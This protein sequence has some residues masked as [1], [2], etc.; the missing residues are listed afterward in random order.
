MSRKPEFEAVWVPVGYV[1]QPGVIHLEG[2]W[3]NPWHQI[4]YA[5]WR[6]RKRLQISKREAADRAGISE[7][8][9]RQLEGGG[10]L[11][12]GRVIEPN[13]RPENLYKALKA[14]GDV[15]EWAFAVLYWDIPEPLPT[16]G[17]DDR[18]EAKL[19]RL[20]ERD[21]AVIETAVDAMLQLPG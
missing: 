17:F 6:G 16:E 14:V 4:G 1:H 21:R 9:W 3:S 11:V 20:S 7:A 15:P 18:L 8:L 2:D 19:A 5:L 12:N 13:P 10:K